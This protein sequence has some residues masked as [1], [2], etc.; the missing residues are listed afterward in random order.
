MDIVDKDHHVASKGILAGRS[1]PG[2]PA[3]EIKHADSTSARRLSTAPG[4]GPSDPD[5]RAEQ[6]ANGV[7]GGT[8]LSQSEGTLAND[9]RATADRPGVARSGFNDTAPQTEHGTPSKDEVYSKD[10][11]SV[12]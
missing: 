10:L 1:P 9:A 6:H 7:T 11:N 5:S 8:N 2:T 12:L 3:K 4:S